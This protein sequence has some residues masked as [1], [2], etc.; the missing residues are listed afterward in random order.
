MIIG[1]SGY[2][3]SGKD[4]SANALTSALHFNRVAFADKLRDFLYKL[5]PNVQS[6]NGIGSVRLQYVINRYGWGAYK[7]TP[8]GAE[9]RELLQRLG[10]EC[11]RGLIHENVWVEAALH[12]LDPDRNYV[13][14]DVRF[15]NEA[16]AIVTEGGYLVR[17]V[18]PGIGPANAHASET[19]LD[20]WRFDLV[21]HND[22]G[23]VDLHQKMYALPR[24]LQFGLW[25]VTLD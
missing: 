23:V 21:I 25:P 18:R 20:D 4:E 14:T 5:N 10:T 3:R 1:L 19:A 8:W 11:G 13:V 15:P 24:L 17:I 7:E 9:I 22:G 16:E 12:G 2:A 6:D